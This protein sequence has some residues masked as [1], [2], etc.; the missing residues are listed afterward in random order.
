MIRDYSTP[1]QT[2][3]Y[4]AEN[5][6]ILNWW[7]DEHDQL[8]LSQIQKDHWIWHSYI[9][10]QI[11][12]ITPIQA[13][14]HWREEDPLCKQYAWYNVLMNFAVA[15]AKQ[16][17]FTQCIRLPQEKICPICNKVFSEANIPTSIVHCLGIDRLDICYGCLGYKFS[18]GSGS[19]SISKE[20]IIKYFQDLVEIIQIIPNQ[21]FGETPSSLKYLTTEKRVAV[22][23]INDHKPTIR[24]IKEVF[25]SW[26]NVLIQ[27]N[28]LEAARKTSRG[29]QCIAQD[30]HLCFSL[31]EKTI[32][33]YLYNHG[34]V[35]QKEPK[36]P[37]GNYKGDF[38]CGK[39]IIEFF[40][41]KGNPDYD[42]KT[43]EKI[44]ICKKH[45][46]TLIALYP[47]NLVV[48]DKLEQKL[49]IL[50]SN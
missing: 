1:L 35:H 21:N 3:P 45:N 46:I 36:Y 12:K 31:G 15:R 41:L 37:E 33:D 42:L 11:T 49:S 16:L 26:L 50:K 29:I 34:I 43:K 28:I 9:T 18:Q 32:D 8:V 20:E 38:L 14:K 25:G 40:G 4:Y 44:N 48:Q 13:I 47:E 27:S 10:E 2:E 19:D 24:R 30:G 39:V 22:L 17:G 6:L 23:K 5:Q 7:K